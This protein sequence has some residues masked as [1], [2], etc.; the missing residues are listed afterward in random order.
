MPEDLPETQA[1]TRA[2]KTAAIKAAIREKRIAQVKAYRWPKGVSGNPAGRPPDVLDEAQSILRVAHERRAVARAWV[3]EAQE[4]NIFAI[5]GI[6]ER[7]R[8]KVP[9]AIT[10]ADDGPLAINITV[11]HVGDPTCGPEPKLRD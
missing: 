6:L 9:Q 8:G 11:K 7:Q 2:E 5:N 10:G 1:Q 4:G 3:D